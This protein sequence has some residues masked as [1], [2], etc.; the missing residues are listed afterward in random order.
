M[1]NTAFSEAK[2]LVKAFSEASP[3][4]DHNGINYEIALGRKSMAEKKVLGAAIRLIGVV[5]ES[6]LGD[7]STMTSYADMIDTAKLTIATNPLPYH[8]MIA[9]LEKLQKDM[10]QGWQKDS[11]GKF[12]NNGPAF[13]QGNNIYKVSA[14]MRSVLLPDQIQSGLTEGQVIRLSE[15][16]GFQNPVR[17]I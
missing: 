11:N 1:E 3:T 15:I 5:S 8:T 7:E 16:I 14:I 10:G 4:Q 17:Q 2:K 6:M 9:S 13:N 12:H